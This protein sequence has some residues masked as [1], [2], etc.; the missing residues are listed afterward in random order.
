MD[1]SKFITGTI[2]KVN[3]EERKRRSRL[4]GNEETVKGHKV[5]WIGERRE[6]RYCVC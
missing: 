2:T 3:G 4:L 1:T 5:L 6:D